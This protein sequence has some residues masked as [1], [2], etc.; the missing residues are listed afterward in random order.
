MKYVFIC[1]L[2]LFSSCSTSKPGSTILDIECSEQVVS[3]DQWVY[4]I[5]FYENDCQLDSCFVPKG[6]TS[7]RMEKMTPESNGVMFSFLTF[8]ETL[9][10]QICIEPD[11]GTT[12]RVI[13]DE[14]TRFY[15][16]TEGSPATKASYEEGI[17]I[18][19]LLVKIHYYRDLL[20]RY[21]PSVDS[22]QY[23]VVLDSL[24]YY[25]EYMELG[26]RL[27]LL[28]HTQVP[29]FYIGQLEALDY[30]AL[31]NLQE[32]DSLVVIMKKRFPDDEKVQQYPV[33]KPSAPASEASKRHFTR[34]YEILDA[35]K[36]N[37]FKDELS[38]AEPAFD[39][40]S[41]KPYQTNDIVANFIL[42]SGEGQS[43]ALNDIGSE[44][45][46]LDF[47]ASWC[48]PCRKETQPLLNAL[49]KY[50]KQLSL[51]AISIDDSRENWQR[52][53]KTDKS[54]AMMHFIIGSKNKNARYIMAQFGIRAIPANFLLDQQR[55]I[56]AINLRGDDLENKMKELTGK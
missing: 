17:E 28:S 9:P 34:Y 52:A 32:H 51:V 21:N 36:E 44:Y 27:N 50:A 10:R 7:F 14:N 22:T 19:S 24:N 12:V 33:S 49:K 53:I 46:L 31:I 41:V 11:Y 23:R 30:L 54:E 40:A 8:A 35:K 56:I 1:I 25:S 3:A 5:H 43:V 4:W 48:M 20:A 45:I 29:S 37:D 18:D 55:R 2:M 26:R 16:Y 42:N 47:W 39:P 6:R 15:P 38:D 13:I